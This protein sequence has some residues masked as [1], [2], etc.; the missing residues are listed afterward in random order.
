MSFF[1]TM[2]PTALLPN[3]SATSGSKAAA[4]AAVGKGVD[5]ATDTALDMVQ[6]ATSGGKITLG[7]IAV[8]TGTSLVLGNTGGGKVDD[9]ARVVQS[10][11]KNAGDVL[12]GVS[13]AETL[14]N[15]RAIGR[16]Y[17]KQ[18]LMQ[19]VWMQMEMW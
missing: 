5:V 18:E 7:S 1:I 13:K 14:A 3:S 8:S 16:A 4:S 10:G 9:V 17:E 2:I 19:L 12:G 15:N 11:S 6:T